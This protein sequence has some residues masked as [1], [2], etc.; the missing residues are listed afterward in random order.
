DDASGRPGFVTI[1]RTLHAAWVNH[2]QDVLQQADEVYAAMRGLRPPAASGA[3][4]PFNPAVALSRALV[5][6][7]NDSDPVN[8]GIGSGPQKFPREPIL[9]LLLSEYR[10]SHSTKVREALVGALDAM[11]S[12]AFTIIS[13]A[14]S[15]DT[16][17]SPPGPSP[18][19][20]RC[21][22]TTPNC[23]A[24]LRKLIN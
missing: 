16:A 21:C 5:E 11:A 14:V 4:A 10:S 12:A 15:T 9:A 20:R 1:I 22:T 23:S 24:S 17:P 19:L 2:H 7:L 13:A 8:G 6:V 3:A 18:T